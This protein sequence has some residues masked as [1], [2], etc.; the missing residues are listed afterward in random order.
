KG[1]VT[2]A[3]TVAKNKNGWWYVKDGKVDFDY[4]G[5]AENKNG[6]WYIDNGKVD[7]DYTGKANVKV[8]VKDGKVNL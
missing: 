7:F 4:D 5:I 6:V 2:F 1:Q 3:T 8:T